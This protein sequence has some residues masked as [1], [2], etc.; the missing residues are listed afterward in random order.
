MM[1]ERPDL[2]EAVVHTLIQAAET[3]LILPA[4]LNLVFSLSI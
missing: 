2:R 1:R 3:V 4:G